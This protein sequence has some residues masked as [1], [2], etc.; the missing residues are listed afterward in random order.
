MESGEYLEE[1][2]QLFNLTKSASAPEILEKYLERTLEIKF[3]RILIPHN[4]LKDEFVRYHEAFIKIM[5]ILQ[6]TNKSLKMSLFSK[7]QLGKFLFNQGVYAMCKDNLLQ[8]G[9][10]FQDAYG[11]NKQNVFLLTYLGIIL[12]LRKNYYAA[13][14]YFGDA[15]LRDPNNP[16]ACFYA[17][18]NFFKA[19]SYQKAIDYLEKAKKINPSNT[20]IPLRLKYCRDALHKKTKPEAKETFLRHIVMYVRNAFKP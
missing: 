14:K 16:D 7:D 15:L 12:T 4:G 8:A 2:L 10:K 20:E 6:T 11:I 1:L 13:E 18:E 17:A 19:G 3:Q 9:E 5:K